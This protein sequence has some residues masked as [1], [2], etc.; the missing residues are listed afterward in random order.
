MICY[1][2]K[3]QERR[4]I[5]WSRLNSVTTANSNYTTDADHTY[6]H[7]R[8]GCQDALLDLRLSLRTTDR[9]KVS[10]RILGRDRLSS[11]RLTRHNNRLVFLKPMYLHMQTTMINIKLMNIQ[12]KDWLTC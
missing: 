4:G 3:W 5:E 8:I 11:A 2:S 9:R 1:D 12:C 10:H 7:N 6:L